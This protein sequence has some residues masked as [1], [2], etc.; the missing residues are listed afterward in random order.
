MTGACGR[1]RPGAMPAVRMALVAFALHIDDDQIVGFFIVLVGNSV[2]SD[3]AFVWRQG[4]RSVSMV[5]TCD[6]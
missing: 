4:R 6:V 5:F 3:P 2:Q 1:I